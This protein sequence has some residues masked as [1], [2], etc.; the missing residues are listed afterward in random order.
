MEQPQM[1]PK[2]NHRNVDAVVHKQCLQLQIYHY[3]SDMKDMIDHLIAVA[4]TEEQIKH[5]LVWLSK[6]YHLHSE[7][8]Y[9]AITT[10][11]SDSGFVVGFDCEFDSI[12]QCAQIQ[13]SVFSFTV[14]IRLHQFESLPRC[15]IEFLERPDILKV[16]VGVHN[17]ALSINDAFPHQFIRVHGLVDIS[18]LHHLFFQTVNIGLKDLAQ[19]YGLVVMKEPFGDVKV[20]WKT[21]HKNETDYSARDSWFGIAISNQLMKKYCKNNTL[22]QEL[23]KFIM[24]E[25]ECRNIQ[26][27]KAM[28]ERFEGSID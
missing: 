28:F 6:Y 12:H 27:L 3:W 20:R 9:L 17:D 7:L 24:T 4:E 1:I 15:L 11:C 21:N 14:I 5:C 2:S 23:S 10:P 18:I 13:F 22:Y 16:G 19:K 25:M 26:K 8:E